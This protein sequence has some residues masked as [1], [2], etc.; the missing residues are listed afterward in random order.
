[1]SYEFRH[2]M[3]ENTIPSWT[4]RLCFF[5]A[6]FVFTVHCVHCTSDFVS[7]QAV[8]IPSSES[9]PDPQSWYFK[10]ESALSRQKQKATI[11]SRAWERNSALFSSQFNPVKFNAAMVHPTPN[12]DISNSKQTTYSRRKKIFTI[13]CL[14]LMQFIL[15]GIYIPKAVVLNSNLG[16][17]VTRGKISKIFQPE[18]HLPVYIDHLDES[19]FGKT[20]YSI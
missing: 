14:I 8:Y 18:R 13:Y 4:L 2:C 1:M 5:N 15:N 12:N 7:W 19:L 9:R 3:H 10:L 6:Y 17:P 20:K 16:N 11:S